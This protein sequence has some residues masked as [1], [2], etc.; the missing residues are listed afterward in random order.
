MTLHLVNKDTQQIL[1]LMKMED[2][3]PLIG[4][5]IQFCVKCG[6]L[7][8]TKEEGELI[9][10]KSKKMEEIDSC[11]SCKKDFT[12]VTVRTNNEFF[13]KSNKTIKKG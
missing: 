1:D 6:E 7:V 10:A 3:K 11:P 9:K 5:T 4:H 12:Q 2:L 13:R 8:V